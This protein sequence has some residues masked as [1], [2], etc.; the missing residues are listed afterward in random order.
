M[1][2]A[3]CQAAARGL[4]RRS[5]QH[6]SLL[7]TVSFRLNLDCCTVP[8][9][10]DMDKLQGSSAVGCPHA[11]RLRAQS[12]PAKAALRVVSSMLH[13]GKAWAPSAFS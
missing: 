1:T 5:V 4:S 13:T 2:P 7:P 12:S 8:G 11:V 9:T 10:A 3:D 6:G